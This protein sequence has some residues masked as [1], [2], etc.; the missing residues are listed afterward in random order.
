M[1]EVKYIYDE[2]TPPKEIVFGACRDLALFLADKGY[3]FFKS[4][5]EITKKINDFEFSVSFYTYSS[6]AKGRR[7]RISVNCRIKN[8]KYNELYYANNLGYIADIGWNEWEL[9][10]KDNYEKSIKE[11]IYHLENRFLPLCDRFINDIKSLVLDVVNHG[12]YPNHSRIRYETSVD[13]LLR[14]GDVKLLEKSIQNYYDKL[15]PTRRRLFRTHL[16][17]VKNGEELHP[18]DT[19]KTMFDAIIKYNLNINMER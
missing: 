5:M 4:K 14:Y 13:F 17:C 15:I 6:N 10:G 8:I 3:K 1:I 11:I 18:M 16:L 2:T 9:Y 7:A 19:E 12:F